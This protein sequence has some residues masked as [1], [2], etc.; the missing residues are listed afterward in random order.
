MLGARRSHIPRSKA[1]PR[2]RTLIAS[3]IQAHALSVSDVPFNSGFL[4]SNNPSKRPSLSDPQFTALLLRWTWTQHHCSSNPIAIAHQIPIPCRHQHC[5]F[6]PEPATIVTQM[7]R[8]HCYCSSNQETLQPLLLWSRSSLQ[9]FSSGSIPNL[10]N[11][12]LFYQWLK[13][14]Y[15]SLFCSSTLSW[16]ALRWSTTLILL[17]SEMHSISYK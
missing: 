14:A 15:S 6:D 7:W 9:I 17:L 2:F 12:G 5:S 8:P 1:C 13:E 4:R 11:F 16:V 10:T 3:K